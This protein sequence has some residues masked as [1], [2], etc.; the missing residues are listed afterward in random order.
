M[1]SAD[2]KARL[3]CD[4]AM[5]RFLGSTVECSLLLLTSHAAAQ[6]SYLSAEDDETF[7]ALEQV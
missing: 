5:R 7:R 4:P 1:G 3:W 2:S 6:S